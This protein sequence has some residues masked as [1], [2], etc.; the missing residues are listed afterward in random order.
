MYKQGSIKFT[1][2]NHERIL[3]LCQLLEH[4]TKRGTVSTGY[5]HIKH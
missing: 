2:K 1:E 4:E 5:T 3:V